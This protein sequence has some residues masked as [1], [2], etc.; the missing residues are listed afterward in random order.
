MTSAS[1]MS[2]E[3]AQEIV[4]AHHFVFCCGLHRSGTTLLFRM[5]REH[6]AMSGFTN[7]QV[8]TEWLALDDEGQYLQTVY[9]PGVVHGGPGNFAFAPAAHLT[10]ESELLNPENNARLAMDWFPYWDLSKPYLLEKSPPNLVM[11][12]FLQS[13]F[14]HTA[15]IAIVRHPVAVSL[16]TMKWNTRGLNSLIEHWLVAHE[17]F[18]KDRPHLQRTITIK[19]EA[20]VSEPGAV[21][22][23]IYAFLGLEPRETSF[24]A[25][26]EH[27][28]RYFAQWLDMAKNPETSASIQE[29]IARH[30]TRVRAFGYSLQDLEIW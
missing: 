26:Q 16:A 27:N 18:E 5:L 11:T 20:L 17:T 23:Q 14:P 21:L 29:C 24:E 6:P 25:T 22:R 10:E 30:E 3:Q 7:N 8:P 9:P 12:R 28:Q 2:L 15:F 13:A 1:A 19:Y 4:Q